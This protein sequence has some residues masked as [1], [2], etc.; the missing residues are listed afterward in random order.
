MN[1]QPRISRYRA[2]AA[3]V[4]ASFKPGL[5]AVDARYTT[6]PSLNKSDI[7]DLFEQKATEQLDAAIAADKARK[8]EEKG[9]RTR[10]YANR[11]GSKP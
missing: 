1:S 5:Y 11:P 2:M 6:I 9:E 3:F 10:K 7:R 4:T 8:E